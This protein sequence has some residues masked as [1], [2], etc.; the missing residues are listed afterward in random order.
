M[1]IKFP[2]GFARR[3]SSGPALDEVENPPESSFKV[4][5]RPDGVGKSFDGPT[6]FRRTTDIRPLSSPGRNNGEGLF[7][8]SRNLQVNNNR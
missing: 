5:E 6:A 7:P 1:P 8:D 3:K 4:F 2:K